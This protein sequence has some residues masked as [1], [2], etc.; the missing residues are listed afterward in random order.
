MAAQAVILAEKQRILSQTIHP[1]ASLENMHM[2]TFLINDL[3]DFLQKELSIERFPETEQGGIYYPSKRPVRRLGLALEPFFRL[4]DW[5]DEAQIDALW[6]HRPWKIDLSR[7]PPDIGVIAHHLPF[8][9]ALTVG[10]NRYLASKLGAI[11]NIQPIGYKKSSDDSG[12]DLPP[13]PIGMLIDIPP[14]EFD[15]LLERV[16][17]IFDGYDRAEAGYGSG[18]WRPDSYRVAVVGAMTDALIREADEKGAH[19]YLTG[20]YR[21]AGQQAVDDTGI[22]VI[23]AGHRRSEEWGMRILA[24]ILE[25]HLSIECV[26]HEPVMAVKL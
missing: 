26:V 7:L 10:Y 2:S 9:E 15:I 8:D 23:A 24:D 16:K 3:A 22:A 12:I 18:G 14:Q 20:A 6:L 19:L 1:S 11:G 21:K 17:T 25:E 5:A 13:R 4:Y